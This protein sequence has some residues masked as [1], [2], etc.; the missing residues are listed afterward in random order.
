MRARAIHVGVSANFLV[1][2]L[3]S[4]GLGTQTAQRSDVNPNAVRLLGHLEKA[5]RFGLVPRVHRPSTTWPIL[6]VPNALKFFEHPRNADVVDSWTPSSLSGYFVIK[7]VR[8]DH[9]TILHTKIF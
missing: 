4:L 7:G 8:D 3:A 2:S 9:D 6:G 1:L 5:T